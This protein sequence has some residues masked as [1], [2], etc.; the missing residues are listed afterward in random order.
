MGLG[1]TLRELRKS[2]GY[3]QAKLADMLNISQSAIAAYEVGTREPS[4][5]MIQRLSQF[6]FVPMSAFLPDSNT[7]MDSVQA[8]ADSLHNNPD[9]RLLFDKTRKMDKKDIRA[10]LTVVNAIAREREA[11]E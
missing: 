6:F 3:S 2:R 7:D 8:I 5:E 1:D 9:L 11:N 10:V 4:M